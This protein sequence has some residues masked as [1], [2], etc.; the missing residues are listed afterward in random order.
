MHVSKN[1]KSQLI[2]VFRSECKFQESKL[3]K[4]FIKPYEFASPTEFLLYQIP[5]LNVY[6][7]LMSSLHYITIDE[8]QT[9]RNGWEKLVAMCCQI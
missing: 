3:T 2:G 9:N 1:F 4:I 8:A 6:R 7:E 5:H